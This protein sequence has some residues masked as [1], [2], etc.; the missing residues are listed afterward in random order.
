MPDIKV[1]GII[2]KPGIP[3]APAIVTELVNWL[4]ARNVKARLDEE[5]ALGGAAGLPRAEV[6]GGRAIGD[7]PWRR[8]HAALGGAGGGARSLCCP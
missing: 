3:L 7:R 2:A 1:V 5:A 4:D 6:P 8:R